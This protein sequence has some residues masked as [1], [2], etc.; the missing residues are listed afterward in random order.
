[1]STEIFFYGD[2]GVGR[3]KKESKK[4]FIGYFGGF[5][6]KFGQIRLLLNL[7]TSRRP[8]KVIT[9]SAYGAALV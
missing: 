6:Q 5:L 3:K 7:E 4:L 9:R 1:M 2:L 8:Q